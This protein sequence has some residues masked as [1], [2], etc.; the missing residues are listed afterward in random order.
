MVWCCKKEGKK[1]IN[2][3]IRK[4]EGSEMNGGK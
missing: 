4:I 2:G 1:K 3:R